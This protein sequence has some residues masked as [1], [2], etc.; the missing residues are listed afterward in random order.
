VIVV[1]IL[2]ALT[3]FPVV[4]TFGLSPDSGPGLVFKTLP[5]LFAKLP[6]SMVI[7]TLFFSL[8]VFTALTSAVPLVE[9]VAT[10]LME[11]FGWSRKVATLRVCLITFLFGIPSALS[12]TDW[13]FTRWQSIFG[14]NFLETVDQFASIWVIPL[15]GLFTALFIGYKMDKAVLKKEFYD[16]AVSKWGFNIW[17]YAISVVVPLV[18]LLIIL[19]T[20]GLITLSAGK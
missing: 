20:S 5:V 11:K 3:I 6:G 12:N 8:F 19:Q 7:S 9:V 18:I 13:M 4:F 14:K 10:N 16:G 2:S 15:A 1:A 17:Y